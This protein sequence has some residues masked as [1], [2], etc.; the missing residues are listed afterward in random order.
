LHHGCG[1]GRG[2]TGVP[3]AAFVGLGPGAASAVNG[4][5]YAW[6][7]RAPLV[8]ISDRHSSAVSDFTTHQALE[9]RALFAS[10]VKASWVI[11]PGAAA[12][13]IAEA[14]EL[15]SAEP[16]GPVHLELASDVASSPASFAEPR[17]EAG[18]PHEISAFEPGRR[19]TTLFAP[20]GAAGRVTVPR[21]GG[22]PG[23]IEPSVLSLK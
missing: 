8:L 4:V 11:S 5:A 9:Q 16:R 18:P 17:R 21:R 19:A 1:H 23:G 10:V 7:D 2:L 15:A 20:T 12:G 3:G 6:L 14:L 13:Q 22:R